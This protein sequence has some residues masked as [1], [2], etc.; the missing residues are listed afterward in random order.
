M[1]KFACKLTVL[2]LLL[3]FA[4]LTAIQVRYRHMHITGNGI[5]VH[6]HPYSPENNHSP[7]QSHSHSTAF[8]LFLDLIASLQ[9]ENFHSAAFSPAVLMLVAL[10]AL[11]AIEMPRFGYLSAGTGRSPPI[12]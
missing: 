1:R 11:P 12:R 8:A 6:A 3:A 7:V 9:L 10:I 2:A 5:I 4:W